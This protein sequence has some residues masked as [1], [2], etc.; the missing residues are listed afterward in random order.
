MLATTATANQRVTADVAAQLGADTVTLRGSLARASLRL[1]VVPALSPLERYAWVADALRA[2]ARLGHR[3][4]AHRRRD[5]AGGRLPDQQ[6]HDVAAY[7]G[8]THRPGRAG[9]PAAATT[10][11]RRWWRPR[12]WAWATTSPIWRSACT[13]ARRPRRWPTTSRSAG[14]VGR[15]TTPLAVLVPSRGGRADLGVLRHRRAS[16]RRRRSSGSWMRWRSRR[17]A[18]AASGRGR[19]RD[20]PRPA[21]DGAQDPGRRRRGRTACRAAGSRP[22]SG[23]TSTRPSG[24]RCAR[25]G[26]PR[27]DLMRGV[28]ARRGLPDAVPAAGAGRSRSAT[29]RALLGLRPASCRHRGAAGRPATVEAARQFF[30]GQDVVVEPRKLW[31]SGLPGS[32]GKINFLA[33]GA[34][35]GVRGR[36]GLVERTGRAVA[37]RRRRRP[38]VILDGMVEVLKRWSTDLAATG[39][40]GGGAVPAVPDSLVGSVAEHLA[41]IGRLPLVDALAV[42]G[43]P[44]SGGQ[45]LVACGPRTCCPGRR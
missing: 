28:R 12:R 17:A 8:Q 22:G 7:S 30:R 3:L 14:P 34:G 20:P 33:R 5:G 16:R 2:T 31:V 13:W 9:G 35:A 39:R 29:L 25:C 38:P 11:S 24:R 40:R 6:G 21:G 32:K 36:S 43:P 37:A 10:R 26:R 18:V 15:W 45:R 41:R 23:G 4:R 27:P 1:A 42:T 44:P 19:H